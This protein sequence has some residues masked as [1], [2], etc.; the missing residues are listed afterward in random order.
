MLDLTKNFEAIALPNDCK[1]SIKGTYNSLLEIGGAT[2]RQSEYLLSRSC[3][4]D[5]CQ[6]LGL[7][8]TYDISGRDRQVILPPGLTHSLSHSK[9]VAVA[10]I[11]PKAKYQSLGIDLEYRERPLTEKFINRITTP[12]ER[13]L[14]NKYPDDRQLLAT[15]IFSAKESVFK[16]C[17]QQINNFSYQN[18]EI[19]EDAGKLKAI[20]INQNEPFPVLNLDYGF[21]KQT[22]LVTCLIIPRY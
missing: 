19:W 6:N 16:A 9:Q 10:I 1:V 22:H 8:F 3:L 20:V 18:M 5:C 11:G 2:K 17:S 4:S 13:E 15:L 14:L 12:L 21:Y 7:K